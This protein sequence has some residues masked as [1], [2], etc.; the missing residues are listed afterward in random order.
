[1]PNTMPTLCMAGLVSVDICDFVAGRKSHGFTLISI[2]KTI[3]YKVIST[4]I[5]RK[6][7]MSKIGR[8][9]GNKDYESAALT[10]ELRAQNYL[11]SV[12]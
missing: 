3:R 7:P 1:M 5:K 10:I 2:L 8:Q 9:S 12:A 11:F 6:D 4:G